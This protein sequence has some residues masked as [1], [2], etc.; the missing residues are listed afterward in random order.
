MG[1]PRSHELWLSDRGREIVP[2]R[3]SSHRFVSIYSTRSFVLFGRLLV[4]AAP[5]I[6]TSPPRVPSAVQSI[7]V[8]N[9][10][11]RVVFL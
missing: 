2:F 1:G 11:T 7:C 10:L 3:R 5:L 9:S 4:F 6:L 8:F